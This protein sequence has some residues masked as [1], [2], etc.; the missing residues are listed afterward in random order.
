MAE[1]RIADDDHF[2]LTVRDLD[3][4]D[5]E[6][7]VSAA[8]LASDEI[9]PLLNQNRRPKINIFSASYTRHRHRASYGLSRSVVL[10]MLDLE[11]GVHMQEQVIKVTKT[12]ISPVTQLA[13]FM[14]LEWVWLLFMALSSILY[15]IME[16]LS[17]TY[18]GQ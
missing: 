18:S 2:E 3:S 1:T 13:S 10:T 9:I 15:L 14:G 11:C 7:S 5:L 17:Y 6:K 16:L 4:P 12:E 8:S